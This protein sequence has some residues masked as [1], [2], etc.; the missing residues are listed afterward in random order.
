MTV[1]L[2]PVQPKHAKSILRW[3]RDPIIRGNLGL[4]S[5]P[6]MEKTRAFIDAA[7]NDP[8]VCARAIVAD[9]KHVGMVTI[10]H[11]ERPIDKGRLHI[12][13]GESA[14]RG[15]GVGQKALQL[16]LATAFDELRLHKVWLTVHAKNP[17]AIAAY[18]RVGFQVEGVHRD[19]FSL[20]GE[21]VNELYMGILASEWRR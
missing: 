6:T 10:D 21:R 17:G 18:V 13:V 12:Y 2:V 16:A 1:K 15:Q 14:L 9:G 7:P 4:R 11:I 20:D 3:L 8:S 5:T 19:E